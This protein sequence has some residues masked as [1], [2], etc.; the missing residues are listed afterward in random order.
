M[1]P[2]PRRCAAPC[3][4]R[5]ARG[6]PSARRWLRSI[7]SRNLCVFHRRRHAPG[8]ARRARSAGRGRRAASR[9]LDDPPRHGLP[10]PW[11][12]S[13]ISGGP[14]SPVMAG[15]WGARRDQRRELG[16]VPLWAGPCRGRRARHQDCRRAVAVPRR[17][18]AAVGAAVQPRGS[19]SGLPRGLH[20]RRSGAPDRRHARH[21]EHDRFSPLRVCRAP[22][23]GRITLDGGRPP[24][25]KPYTAVGLVPTVRGIR[26][27][28]DIK[29]NLD[30]LSHLVKAASWL[31]SLD[32]PVRL[33]AFPEGA[34]QAFNDEVLDLDHATFARECAIDIPGDETEALGKIANEASYPE[35][36][37]A[38]ALNG[39]EV[40]YR[41]SYPHPA[42]GNEMFEIQ[43][44]ARALD[45]NLY[46]VAPN[47]GTYY[48]FPEETTPIDT[49]G[50]RS[51]VIDYK[52][53][54]VGK[55]EYGAGSTYVAGVIDIEALRDHRARAQWDNWLKDVR[56]ELYQ[57]L[58]EQPIYPK[59]LYLKRAPMKHAEYRDKV[60]KRQIKLMHDRGIWTKPE[61]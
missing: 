56:T 3:V 57:L 4:S 51:Y 53:R 48:L 52:G 42:T 30:H 20:E 34:L 9:G 61:R 33:I 13:G 11:L 17:R 54:I 1:S 14:P 7:N 28:K 21:R 18:R 55:Q 22:A 35:N 43:S 29:I 12:V 46:I 36:A 59:N 19:T 31:S 37:R 26:K 50:G 45:N 16:R 60:I 23:R 27:R 40:V 32:L 8:R 47:M 2:S 44:R 39:A 24:M 58:Y 49:F 25:I 5:R 41:A 15:H 10:D 38:L 6:R